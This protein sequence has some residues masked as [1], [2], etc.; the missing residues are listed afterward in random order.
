MAMLETL[1][2]QNLDITIPR[3][4]VL[5][6]FDGL[7]H[8]YLIDKSRLGQQSSGKSSVIE[9][10]SGIKTPRDTGTCTCCPL[11]ITMQPSD[12]PDAV[13]S[14][15]ISLQ[16]DYLPDTR[17]PAEIETEP[18]QFF[19][20]WM[21]AQSS[22]QISFAETNSQAELERLIRCAQAANLSPQEDPASFLRGVPKNKNGNQSKFSPNLVRIDITEPGMPTLNFFDL[23]GI[24]SQAE[25][26]DEE[27][28]V[29]LVGN[30][31]S[32]YIRQPGS[33]ILV[34]CDLGTDIANS[35]AA[36]LARKH[37]AI[38]RCIGMTLHVTTAF[39]I[40]AY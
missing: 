11:Y 33:L 8:R 30:M 37:G 29:T 9:A 25:N 24:I 3:C 16:R 4:I 40:S 20:K 26:D 6:M 31:V 32:E 27:Y 22:E 18:P 17:S 5:G 1:G 10:I 14:A 39:L 34:T 35:T 13:W 12:N 19:P 7:C 21:H 2:L 23:P 15:K 38:D 36:A 28:T